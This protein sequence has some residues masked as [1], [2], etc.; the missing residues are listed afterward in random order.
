[1]IVNIKANTD[2]KGLWTEETREVLITGLG[3]GYSSLVYYPED[4]FYGELRAHFISHGYTVG[5]WNV[6][7]HG[8]IYTDKLWMKEF[9]KG[10]RAAGFSILAVRD[11]S[12]SEKG[13]QGL[14]YV[15]LDIGVN[16]Y[17]SWKRLN[18]EEK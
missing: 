10:L 11:V 4:P 18:K 17:K 9:K 2:G 14:D 1:M 13:L 5:S 8:L 3:I 16:F 6:D 15:S 7:G 12:Y